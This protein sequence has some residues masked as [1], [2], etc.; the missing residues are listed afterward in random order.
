MNSKPFLL[1]RLWRLIVSVGPAFFL[2]G[3]NIGTGSV[4]A[5]A[6]AG[7][8]YGMSL[9][10]AL[11]LSCVFSFV[12]LEA[13][14]RYTIVTGKSALFS[15]RQFH[16]WGKPIAL[17]TLIGLIVVEV[18]ALAGIMGIMSD[19]IREWSKMFVTSNGWNPIWIT[20]FMIVSVYLLITVGKYTFFEK[21][22]IFFV[23]IM[24]GSF[25]LTMFIVVPSPVEI[26]K[27]SIPQIPDEANASMIIG[28]LVGATLTAPTYIVR[29]ILVKEKGWNTKHLKLG[30]KDAFVAALMIFIISVSVMVCAAGTLYLINKPVE[31]VITM[32][33]LL[34]PFAGRFALSVFIL[35]IIGAGLS[36]IIPIAMLAPL[37]IGDYRGIP[38]NMKSPM[39]RILCAAAMTFGLI[40]PVFHA[41]PV[42]AMIASQCFQIPMLPVVTVSIFYLLNRKDIMGEHKAGFWLNLGFTAT[43]IF[44]FIITYQ[45]ILGLS[46]YFGR[47]F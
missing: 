43:L 21:V 23:V 7:S 38:V 26:I 24:E 40:I 42:L 30:R 20:V 41:R 35:G 19:L 10:W 33:V 32:V 22:L 46:H 5:M 15:Y 8:R 1:S 4:V 16:F 14:G 47:V 37:L 9:L 34:E 11:I 18:M 31:D 17:I 12:M 6:S 39:F 45:S 2:I 29:S 36:S 3:Y 25:I 28:A 27:G 13:Y 44:S